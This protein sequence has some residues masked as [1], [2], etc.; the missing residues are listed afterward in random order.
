MEVF[1][2]GIIVALNF[3]I[4]KM[5][6]DKHRY[7]DAIFDGLLL[8]GITLLFSGSYAGLAVGTVASLFISLFFLKSPPTFFSGPSGFFAEFKRR[9]RR[10][11]IDS[12]DI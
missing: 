12:L 3:A 1:V 11:E 9:A 5:K 8:F 7:E 10:S 6:L 4:I 2:L